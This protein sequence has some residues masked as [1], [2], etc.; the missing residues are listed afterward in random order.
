GD[1]LPRLRR[2]EL[3]RRLRPRRRRRLDRRLKIEKLVTAAWDGVPGRTSLAPVEIVARRPTAVCQHR[4]VLEP[5]HPLF[6]RRYTRSNAYDADW[7]FENQMGPHALW[8]LE[9]LTEVLTIE[10]GMRVLDLGC[11]RAM[12]SIFLARELGAEVWA[13]DLWVA[14]DD[15]DAR[16]R[17]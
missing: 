8:L 2:R 1:P 14:A 13:T 11:G 5:D 16:I 10:P 15:N 6:H 9:S 4:A 12:T 7:V 3:L 17:A